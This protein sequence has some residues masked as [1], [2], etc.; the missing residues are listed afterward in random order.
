MV[1]WKDDLSVT[2]RL[3]R[4]HLQLKHWR[5]V[6]NADK[7]AYWQTRID[8]LLDEVVTRPPL[9]EIDAELDQRLAV[10]AL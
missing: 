2:Y 4:S 8:E 9:Q 7:I 10:P 1:P 3:W 6:G 5:T